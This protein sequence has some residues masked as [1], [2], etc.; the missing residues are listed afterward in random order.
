MSCRPP[1]EKKKPAPGWSAGGGRRW[2][3]RI[4]QPN[5]AGVSGRR[6]GRGGAPPWGTQR[7]ADRGERSHVPL[8][9]RGGFTG[10]ARAP[11]DK[12]ASR[13]RSHGPGRHRAWPGIAPRPLLFQPRSLQGSNRRAVEGCFSKSRANEPHFSGRPVQPMP[14]QGLIEPGPRHRSG[15]ESGRRQLLQLAPG[16]TGTFFWPAAA[17]QPVR[18]GARL[19]GLRL[20]V[21]VLHDAPDDGQVVPA[22]QGALHKK[23]RGGE[24]ATLLVA[25][26][27]LGPFRQPPGARGLRT[28]SG[29]VRHFARVLG[30][31]PP[32]FMCKATRHRG[33]KGDRR[34]RRTRRQPTPRKSRAGT[35]RRRGG[36][37]RP[38]RQPA[39]RRG[40]KRRGRA[41]G[42]RFS[43]CHGGDDVR[44]A[45]RQ[46]GRVV[47]RGLRPEDQSLSRDAKWMAREPMRAR[48]RT[49]CSVVNSLL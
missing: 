44:G 26:G 25:V 33:R 46:P 9:L 42:Q 20:L 12:P 36:R 39:A 35:P 15:R 40:C 31:P 3:E 41:G 4:R 37:H 5:S 22:L 24:F 8:F 43:D 10:V 23:R 29:R 32:R 11:E 47:G 45:A 27:E 28:P 14:G 7:N 34:W 2:S 13:C 19:F 1:G 48:K 49:F 30:H 21:L 6:Q 18:H 16:K 17:H 38:R